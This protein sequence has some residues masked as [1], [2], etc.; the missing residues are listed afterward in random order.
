ML[1]MMRI[2]KELRG[3]VQGDDGEIYRNQRDVKIHRNGSANLSVLDRL[4]NWFR[5]LRR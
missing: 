3:Q 4:Q 5:T 1:K 2:A